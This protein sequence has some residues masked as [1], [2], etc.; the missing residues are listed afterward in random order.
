MKMGEFYRK[1]GFNGT[2]RVSINY[3]IM[4]KWSRQNRITQFMDTLHGPKEQV[5]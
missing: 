1:D 4:K 2:W 3:E 5:R